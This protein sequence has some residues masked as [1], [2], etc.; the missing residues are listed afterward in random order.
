MANASAT[1]KASDLMRS[2]NLHIHI[3]GLRS[4][5]WRLVLAGMILRA[6]AAIAG[7]NAEITVEIDTK[8]A[9]R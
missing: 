5:R 8:E 1:F 2:I 3:K 4:M 9:D 7:A 6:G